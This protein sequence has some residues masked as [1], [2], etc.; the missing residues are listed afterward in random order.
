MTFRIVSFLSEFRI[1]SSGLFVGCDNHGVDGELVI[2]EEVIERSLHGEPARDSL[3][4]VFPSRAA[5]R[6]ALA[7][8]TNATWRTHV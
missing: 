2:A 1:A 4:F 6:D 8:I 3:G 7:L 5:A